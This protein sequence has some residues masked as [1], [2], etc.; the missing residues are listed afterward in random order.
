M[1]HNT[2]LMLTV[3]LSSFNN[4]AARSGNGVGVFDNNTHL[5]WLSNSNL[6]G[7]LEDQQG[8]DSLTFN[9]SDGY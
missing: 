8:S 3:L 1:R 6:L 7:T 2:F 4:S 9:T 5:T